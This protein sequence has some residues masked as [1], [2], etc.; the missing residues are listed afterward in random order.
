MYCFCNSFVSLKLFLEG[1]KKV[2]RKTITKR[3]RVIFLARTR[4]PGE[5]SLTVGK[6]PGAERRVQEATL[7]RGP[8]FGLTG[9]DAAENTGL[10]KGCELRGE[11]RKI[12]KN[13]HVVT[14]LH[15]T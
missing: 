8:E 5:D 9:P 15:K 3:W 10:G 12:W 7:P 4:G 2:D 14:P 6:H 11:G 1:K 13:V